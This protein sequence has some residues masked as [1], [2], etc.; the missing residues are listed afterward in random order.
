M[1]S[2]SIELTLRGN[3]TCAFQ[4]GDLYAIYMTENLPDP[5]HL[6]YRTNPS[7]WQ[8]SHVLCKRV[9]M[10]PCLKLYCDNCQEETFFQ[11]F[12]V[13]KSVKN[14]KRGENII[15]SAPYILYLKKDISLSIPDFLLEQLQGCLSLKQARCQLLLLF[16]QL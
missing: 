3:V 7:S 15:F 8:R 1:A 5:R 4:L 2:Q 14:K 6:S 10:Q 13:F 12:T 9:L 16:L 11:S